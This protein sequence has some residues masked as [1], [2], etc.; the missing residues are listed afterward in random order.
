M[1]VCVCVYVYACVCVCVCVRVCV[2][3][4]RKFQVTSVEYA[5]HLGVIHIHTVQFT[6]FNRYLTGLLLL[7]VTKYLRIHCLW[8][9]PE[10]YL[11]H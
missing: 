1:C 3:G 4:D 9:Q 10:H 5:M 7:C 8:I 6:I 2:F 11:F